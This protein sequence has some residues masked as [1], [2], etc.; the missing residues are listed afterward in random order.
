M[1]VIRYL[2][3]YIDAV[4]SSGN[5]SFRILA[6]FIYGNF[7]KLCGFNYQA[8]LVHFLQLAYINGYSDGKSC[9]HYGHSE[10]F[11]QSGFFCQPFSL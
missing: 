3:K 9:F 10:R 11:L 4:P 2:A 1:H 6:Y 5:K 8:V 7:Y